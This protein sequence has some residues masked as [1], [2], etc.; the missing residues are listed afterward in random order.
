[1]PVETITVDALL[2]TGGITAVTWLLTALIFRTAAFSE[3]TKERFGA[4][5]AAIIGIVLAVAASVIVL[6]TGAAD[7]LNAALTGLIGGLA[8]VG[9]HEV[10]AGARTAASPDA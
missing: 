5:I 9:I 2:T 10:V 3:A 6:G 8:A 7:L 4:A 1:M